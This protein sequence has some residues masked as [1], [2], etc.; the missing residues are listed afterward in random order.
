M[1][2]KTN[3]NTFIGQNNRTGAMTAKK[4]RF[5]LIAPQNSLRGNGSLMRGW[6]TMYA[7][8]TK[9]PTTSTMTVAIAAPL[10][11]NRGI[12]T[13]FI[14]ILAKTRMSEIHVSTTA[15]PQIINKLTRNVVTN[16]TKVNQTSIVSVVPEGKYV[17]PNSTT[18]ISAEHKL[19]PIAIGSPITWL[20]DYSDKGTS[21]LFGDASAAAVISPR[22]P[23]RCAAARL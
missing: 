6:R 18:I 1:P 17:S 23:G 4:S 3:T 14:P 8:I 2:N 19:P 20:T 15:L 10:K 13:K 12:K 21:I 9:R 22:I 16:P 7:V 5:T 11:L